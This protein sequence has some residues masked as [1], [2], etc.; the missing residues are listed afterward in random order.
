MNCSAKK[1]MWIGLAVL[2]VALVIFLI[3]GE[4]FLWVQT[5][6]EGQPTEAVI[7]LAGHTSEERLRMQS[8]VE[9]FHDRNADFLIL[10]MR[11]RYF[12]W[13]WAKKTYGLKNT[14]PE[15]RVLI[16]RFSKTKEAAL[17]RYGGTFVEAQHAVQLMKKHRLQSAVV[18]SSGYHMRRAALA[19]DHTGKTAALTFSYHPVGSPDW[20]WWLQRKRI[21]KILREYKKLV[22]AFF[23]YPSGT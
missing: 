1:T 10:P 18:I 16:G 15:D 12:T 6:R 9:L 5:A 8:A 21:R 23:L 17:E 20:S 14:P 3:F 19:F 22:A 2:L 7:V 11:N 13:A 4:F